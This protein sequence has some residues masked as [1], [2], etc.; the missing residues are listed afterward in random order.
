MRLRSVGLALVIAIAG[1]LWACNTNNPTRPSMSFVAPVPQ[2][3]ANGLAYNFTQQPISVQ[4]VNAVRTGAKAVTY[5]LDVST[6]STFATTAVS[7]DGIAEGTDGTTS[8]TLP[9]LAGNTTY[10]WRS[11][12]VVDGIAGEP[13]ATQSFFVRPNITINVP[14]V[15]TP[16]AG[17]DVFAARPSFTVNNA[18]RTGP[19]GTIFYEFQVSTSAAFSSLISSATVQEQTNTT[20]W[21]PTS[22]LPESTLFWRVRAKDLAA[23][24]TGQF[25]S[26]LQF[27][28]KRGID[29]KKAVIAFGPTQVVDWPETARLTNVYFDPND[30]QIMCTEYD[31]PGWPETPFFGGPDTVYANQWVFTIRDNVWYG[32]AAAWMRAWPQFCKR[33]YDQDFFR[34]SLGGRF[35]FTETVLHTGDVIGVM[36]T[37]PARAWPDMSTRDQRSNIVMVNWPNGR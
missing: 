23:D 33:D 21:S 14:S 25:T 30:D 28:R 29:L 22:D 37:T 9:P 27:Q 13:S 24:V 31:D 32:G 17:S 35:P 1:S 12:A 36:M 16:T 4:I 18:T 6:S 3:P 5:T 20:S 26:A 19:A 2:Q 34:D 8:V 11:R 15:Q 7:R 10:F